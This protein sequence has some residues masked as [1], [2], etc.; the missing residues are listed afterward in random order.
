MPPWCC[1]PWALPNGISLG[2]VSTQRSIGP[3]R[4]HQLGRSM[5]WA[6]SGW[7]PT[8]LCGWLHAPSW[9]KRNSHV[10]T[11]ESWGDCVALKKAAGS[12]SKEDR[13]E[14]MMVTTGEWRWRMVN[15]EW[16]WL[17]MRSLQTKVLTHFCYA[18][19]QFTHISLYTETFYREKFSHRAAFTHRNFYIQ[20][21]VHRDG[22]ARKNITHTHTQTLSRLRT[23]KFFHTQ[24][25]SYKS[26]Y[27]QKSSQTDPLTHTQF[28]SQT[29]LHTKA[30]N[31]TVFAMKRSYTQTLYTQNLLHRRFTHKSVYTE[32]F[33]RKNPF[34]TRIFLHAEVF[35][36][37]S[38]DTDVFTFGN[39]YTQQFFYKKLLHRNVFKQKPYTEKPS[40]AEALDTEAFTHKSFY[41][42]MSLH[43]I[44]K[45]TPL[46][47]EGLLTHICLCTQVFKEELH[48]EVFTQREAST[49]R[50]FYIQTPLQAEVF[51]HK[52]SWTQKLS[53]TESFY[54]EKPC[55]TAALTHRSI[56]TQNLAHTEELL[57]TKPFTQ[58]SFTFHTQEL[59]HTEA[60]RHRSFCT[61]RAFIL[62]LT[63]VKFHNSFQ[64]R[65]SFRANGLRLAFQG[66][67]FISVF[68][69]AKGRPR[70]TK[71]AC[72]D[73]LRRRSHF[74]NNSC[75]TTLVEQFLCNDSCVTTFVGQFLC[76]DSSVTTLVQQLLCNDSSVTTLVGQ[77]L[78]NDSSV[79]TLVG[80]FLCNDSSVTTLWDNSCVTTPV[81]QLL[82]DNS[83]V[84][85]PVSQ[86]LWDN[87]CVTTPVSQLCGTI[88][89]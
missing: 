25:F 20:R 64:V 24:V 42:Q 68:G 76:N 66:H 12:R 85:T 47:T 31:K 67:D 70:T 32:K 38:L 89:V 54:T 11:K 71:F 83:C 88:P 55:H 59:L 49:Q 37:T 77:F 84:T 73:D 43:R 63:Y 65:P 15:D 62:P 74:D 30:C 23:E 57:H 22:F 9:R 33:S 44:F 2:R 80:Q 10:R 8:G 52:G 19:A 6:G 46:H 40:Q 51:S 17:M 3:S 41:T 13:K 53:H 86:L 81:S 7:V 4:P 48:T 75:V 36:Q 5:H 28:C 82:W 39:L 45:Q 87:S 56:Y 29:P 18:Q 78:C 60:F 14:D 58:K 79:T 34:R 16:S 50:S 1:T 26:F 21:L 69:I 35:A 61:G 72:H 27:T